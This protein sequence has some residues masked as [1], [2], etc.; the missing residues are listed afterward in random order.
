M[1]FNKNKIPYTSK[2]VFD[3]LELEEVNSIKFLGT[4]LSSDLLSS[5]THFNKRI[6]SATLKVNCLFKSGF[7]S[8]FSSSQLKKSQYKSFISPSLLHDAENQHNSV[9]LIN[10]IQSTE[11]TIIKRTYGISARYSKSTEL[12]LANDLW[13]MK[14]KFL[15]R[16][17]END[18]TKSLLKFL[19]K[20]TKIRKDQTSLIGYIL[21]ELNH[22]GGFDQI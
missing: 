8:E 21:K 14:N 17:I 4:H 18:Y 20:D 12:N 13:C 11:S 3:T 7:K 1:I 9:K 22:S 10:E 15:I 5:E 2:P 19:L 6:T 16:L